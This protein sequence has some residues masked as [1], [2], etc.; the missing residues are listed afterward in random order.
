MSASTKAVL[1][2]M[3][4]AHNAAMVRQLGQAIGRRLEQCPGVLGTLHRWSHAHPDEH[5]RDETHLTAYFNAVKMGHG[6]AD[7]RISMQGC[8]HCKA[9]LQFVED[10]KTFRQRLGAAKR[11]IIAADKADRIESGLPAAEDEARALIKQ[12]ETTL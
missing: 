6:V 12:Q 4:Y 11:S 9:A 8:S 10:R 1:A 3:A 7:A 5:S 2:C